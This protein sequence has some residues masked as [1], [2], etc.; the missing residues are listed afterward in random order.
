M[1]ENICGHCL[2]FSRWSIKLYLCSKQREGQPRVLAI[3]PSLMLVFVSRPATETFVHSIGDAR[4]SG[5]S[6]TAKI[7]G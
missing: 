2:I 5:K 7:C 1:L 6:G 4:F 3:K